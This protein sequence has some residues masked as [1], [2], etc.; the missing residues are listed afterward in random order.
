MWIAYKQP[1]DQFLDKMLAK[2]GPS[3]ILKAMFAMQANDIAV[4]V[5]SNLGVGAQGS[6]APVRSTFACHH[7]N[8]FFQ[9]PV[10]KR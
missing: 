6:V 5:E 1:S 10:N 8:Y 9:Q 2:A 3:V 4:G 7:L